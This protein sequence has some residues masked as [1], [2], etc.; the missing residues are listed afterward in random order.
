MGLT[1]LLDTTP[2]VT[3]ARPGRERILESREVAASWHFY[4]RAIDIVL[5][6]A[7]L[8]LCAPIILLAMIAIVLVSPG[9]PFYV[10]ERVGLRGRVFRLYK[11][12]TMVTGA[13]AMREELHHLNEADGPVFKIRNDPRLHAF[14]SLLRKLSIDEMPN[15]FNVLL[16]DMAIVGPRPPLPSEVAHYSD[17]AARRLSVKPGI[18]CLWQISGRC[19]ISFEEW[20]VLDNEYIDSWSP[21]GDLAI[22]LKT[23][24][25]VLKG[26][27]AH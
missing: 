22:I 13:H 19:N 17:Y 15:F 9:S 24:P 20:M 23:L 21:L 16:G 27:G 10:Q 12:R 1:N 6:T 25:A 7:I 3:V 5:G 2:R 18:T 11:L 26:V 14:G 8:V 4:K